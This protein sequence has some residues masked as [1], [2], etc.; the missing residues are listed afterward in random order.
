ML[1]HYRWEHS[2]LWVRFGFM[3]VS[4]IALL[5]FF[6][7][8]F[9]RYLQSDVS[10]QGTIISLLFPAAGLIFVRLFRQVQEVTN[11]Y[12]DQWLKA[13]KD[14]EGKAVGGLK[15]TRRTSA[16]PGS[17]RY[18]A[19]MVN[20]SLLLIWIVVLFLSAYTESFRWY[21]VFQMPVKTLGGN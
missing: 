19:K 13:L 5:G 10:V 16:A 12:S 6:T 4:Q 7:N 3:L 18:M 9:A 11:W 8:F 17:T 1:R 15:I 2:S 21:D 14:L 20:T